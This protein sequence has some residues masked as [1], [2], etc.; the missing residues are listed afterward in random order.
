[1]GPAAGPL[2]LS[3]HLTLTTLLSPHMSPVIGSVEAL[4][5]F[6]L[7][8]MGDIAVAVGRCSTTTASQRWGP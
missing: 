4:G 7:A 3:G 2:Q 8:W 5:G 1:M 6:I